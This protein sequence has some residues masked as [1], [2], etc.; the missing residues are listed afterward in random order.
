MTA[1]ALFLT[2]CGNDTT[3]VSETDDV[4]ANAVLP[5]DMPL[6]DGGQIL[7]P[8]RTRSNG[9]IREVI[10]K[11]KATPREV[12]DF[13]IAELERRGYSVNED[14]AD[15]RALSMWGET[16]KDLFSMKGST[17]LGGS[18]GTESLSDDETRVLIIGKIKAE[19]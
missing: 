19:E 10:F 15:D 9:M 2:A 1:L 14:Y 17:K 12:N 5:L 13:Y 6:M 16:D 4:S 8:I 18:V 7:T 3:A 11:V